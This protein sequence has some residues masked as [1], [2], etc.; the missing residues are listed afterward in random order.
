MKQG[1][2]INFE[3]VGEKGTHFNLTL[4]P[5][6]YIIKYTDTNEYETCVIGISPDSEVHDLVT[7]G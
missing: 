1:P 5:D 7:I 2:N 3:V 6:D 4:T